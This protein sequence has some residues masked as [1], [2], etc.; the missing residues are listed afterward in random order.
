[1][2]CPFVS[3]YFSRDKLRRLIIGG[4]SSLHII[5]DFDATI[6]HPDG[7]S[8]WSVLEC[9]PHLSAA[10]REENEHTVS[11]YYPISVDPTLTN[12]QR[13]AAM[14]AWAEVSFS[15]IIRESITRQ[16]FHTILDQS[17]EGFFLREGCADLFHAANT[18]QIP[19]LV[20][21][22]GIGDIIEGVFS[23]MGLVSFDKRRHEAHIRADACIGLFDKNTSPLSPSM[24][25]PCSNVHVIGN[26]FLFQQAPPF[27]QWGTTVCPQKVFD[28]AA[29]ES[30][31]DLGRTH[32][33]LE[34]H[35]ASE[36]DVTH[37]VPKNNT[38][39]TEEV[40]ERIVGL[41]GRVIHVFNKNASLVK[42]SHFESQIKSRS[43]AIVIGD[44]VGD[45]DMASGLS[46]D[47]VLKI[48]FFNIRHKACEPHLQHEEEPTPFDYDSLD[49]KTKDRIQKHLEVFDIVLIDDRSM[50]YVHELLQ[51]I[52]NYSNFKSSEE[53][54]SQQKQIDAID[55]LLKPFLG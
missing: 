53:E 33:P 35:Y 4:S 13:T 40:D 49:D 48:G 1:M 24:R 26:R 47:T 38:I 37:M 44:S 51:D 54:R 15:S 25:Q 3:F 5:S 29:H 21:S 50:F 31:L 36:C 39:Q 34:R 28:F 7:P 23:R 11:Q 10:Y 6:S 14:V 8:S 16:L 32:S 9:S 19:L 41:L 30:A 12:E 43:N 52:A 20:F 55:A 17:M 42:G 27:N 45:A 46:L 22:A 2:L 18:F